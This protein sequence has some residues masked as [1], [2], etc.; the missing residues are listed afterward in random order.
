MFQ[1][2]VAEFDKRLIE[3]RKRRMAERKEKRKEERKAKFYREKEEEA[4]RKRDEELKRRKL[5]HQSLVETDKVSES[6]IR[7]R[8]CL[9]VTLLAR[10]SQRHL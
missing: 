8:H 6:Q 9:N 1:E 3:E 7:F 10:F 4:Q 2:K 5:P